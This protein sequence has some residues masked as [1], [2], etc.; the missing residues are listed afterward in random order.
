ML[1]SFLEEFVKMTLSGISW[2][3]TSC[4]K[5]KMQQKKSFNRNTAI[6]VILYLK[7]LLH[8]RVGFLLAERGIDTSSQAPIE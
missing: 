1:I 5:V 3:N 6:S 8:L 7:N 2:L 4:L